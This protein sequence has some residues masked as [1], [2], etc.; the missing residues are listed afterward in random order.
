MG[1]SDAPAA[2]T[3]CFL[4]KSVVIEVHKGETQ[5]E[6]WQRHLMAHPG[7][8]NTVTKIFHYPAEASVKKAKSHMEVLQ[9]R[10][11]GEK[12]HG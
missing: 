1:H 8:V 4:S 12:C 7:D 2:L 6:A 5:E 9:F 10:K 11:Q 3:R